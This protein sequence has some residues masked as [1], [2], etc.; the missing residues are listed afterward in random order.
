MRY[1][2]G[3]ELC[4]GTQEAAKYDKRKRLTNCQDV[5]VFNQRMGL[6]LNTLKD[7]AP[8][9]SGRTFR[10]HYRLGDVYVDEA[11]VKWFVANMA[12]NSK[13]RAE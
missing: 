1:K 13:E 12:G 7:E 6:N 5:Y 8:M 11:G 4:K 2:T 9:I 3:K 10:P